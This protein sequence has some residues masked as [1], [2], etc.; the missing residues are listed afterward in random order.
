MKNTMGIFQRTK[1]GF[2][3]VIIDDIDEDVFIPSKKTLGAMNGD[4]VEIEYSP[5]KEDGKRYEG[6]IINII[7]RKTTS[8]V[9]T[10]RD[11]TDFGFVEVE[12]VKLSED[13]F[14][15]KRNKHSL[16]AQDCQIVVVEIKIYSDGKKKAQG[17]ITEVLGYPDEDGVEIATIIKRFN[18][19][20]EFGDKVEKEVS[21][22]KQTVESHDLKNRL[23]LRDELIITIY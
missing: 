18:L 17:I 10:Y 16:K 3:F 4:V 8:L 6:S 7:E 13:I 11:C 1:R 12:D 22:I 19:S 2:G 23:D 9:G 14:V 15:S 5:N 20:T 21:S